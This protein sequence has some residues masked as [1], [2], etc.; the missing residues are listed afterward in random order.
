MQHTKIAAQ[1]WDHSVI[2]VLNKVAKVFGIT[3]KYEVQFKI[4][5]SLQQ[6]VC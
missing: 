5:Q 1:V 2:K 3:K 4:E 6:R